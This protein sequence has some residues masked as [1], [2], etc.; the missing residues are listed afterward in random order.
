MIPLLGVSSVDWLMLDFL[1]VPCMPLYYCLGF[2]P[3]MLHLFEFTVVLAFNYYR[4]CEMVPTC[5]SWP[6]L[7]QLKRWPWPGLVFGTISCCE[8]YSPLTPGFTNLLTVWFA[9]CNFETVVVSEGC[10]L[11]VRMRC[12]YEEACPPLIESSPTEGVV[13]FVT[14]VKLPGPV[15]MFSFYAPGPWLIDPFECIG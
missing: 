1:L 2:C 9:C 5:T 13:T 3:I 14:P 4:V 8:R 15:L 12:A 6:L 10:E 11:L 7:P